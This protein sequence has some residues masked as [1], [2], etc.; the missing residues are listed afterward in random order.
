MFDISKTVSGISKQVSGH[1]SGAREILSSNPHISPFTFPP[2]VQGAIAVANQLGIK[3]PTEAELVKLA[4]GEIDNILGGLG[5]DLSS[6]LDT[7]DSELGRVTKKAEDVQEVLN[8]LSWL[9]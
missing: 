3:V 6:V 1:I 4:N 2:Q 8:S 9:L 7:V 5:K